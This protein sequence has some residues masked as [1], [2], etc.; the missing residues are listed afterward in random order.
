MAFWRNIAQTYVVPGVVTQRLLAR[1]PA[2]R[3]LLVYVMGA[4]LIGFLA[5]LPRLVLTYQPTAE[6]PLEAYFAANLV[7]GLIFAPL[8]F[9]LLAACSHLVARLFGGQGAW[10]DTRLTLFWCLLAAQP[11]NI[12][13][14]ILNHSSDLPYLGQTMS[15]IA[16]VWFLGIWGLSLRAAHS[17]PRITA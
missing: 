14:E 9:Y 1:N 6:A 17:A 12:A 13:L 16:A 5:R 15:L 11:V 8:F 7:A 3:L 10:K 4:C 2:E